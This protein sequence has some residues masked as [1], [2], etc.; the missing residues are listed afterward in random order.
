MIPLICRI[1]ETKHTNKKKK[2]KA[3]KKKLNYRGHT[4]LPKGS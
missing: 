3:K 2:D 1:E 4:W